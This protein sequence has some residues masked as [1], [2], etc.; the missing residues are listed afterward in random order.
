MVKSS[1]TVYTFPGERGECGFCGKEEGGYAKKD[2]NGDWQAACWPCVRPLVVGA[3]Q[4]KRKFVGT[5]YTDVN[6]DADEVKPKAV[7]KNPG[8]APSNYRPKV[9]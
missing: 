5:V 3:S 7:K 1:A 4:V 8:I 6:A 9:N 2:A